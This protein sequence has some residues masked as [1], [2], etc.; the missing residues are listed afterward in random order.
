MKVRYIELLIVEWIL[1]LI[2]VRD[3]YVCGL[4]EYIENDLN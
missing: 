4:L 2:F 3:M 1:D